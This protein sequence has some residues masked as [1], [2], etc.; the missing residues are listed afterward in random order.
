MTN[1]ITLIARITEYHAADA[2]HLVQIDA[3]ELR[4]ALG[5]EVSP[6]ANFRALDQEPIKTPEGGEGGFDLVDRPIFTTKNGT[7]VRLLGWTDD[8]SGFFK[9]M[10]I[11]W[12]DAR[13]RHSMT[14]YLRESPGE[15]KGV[16]LRATEDQNP[17]KTSE[18]VKEEW[19]K[20]NE[21]YWRITHG[22]EVE[23]VK[24]EYLADAQRHAE[25]GNLFGTHHPAERALAKQKALVKYRNM[26]GVAKNGM[27]NAKHDHKLGWKVGLE[28]YCRTQGVIYFTTGEECKAAIKAMG[29]DMDLLLED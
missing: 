11:M 25:V 7:K 4:A 20:T 26:P 22:G 2:L 29:K 28:Q 23:P 24:F 27:W 17:I 19:P 6:C 8:D 14:L 1:K 21:L 10:K 13:G 16:P 15:A 3:D 18:P 9:S 12:D 5:L